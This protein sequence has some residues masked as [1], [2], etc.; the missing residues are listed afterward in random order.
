MR[1]RLVWFLFLVAT[2]FLAAHVL[3]NPNATALE[4]PANRALLLIVVVL[5]IYSAAAVGTWL[6]I[7]A[8]RLRGVG[9][10]P[11][12]STLVTLALTIL[13]WLCVCGSGAALAAL[14]YLGPK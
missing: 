2:V 9:A 4:M 11:K 7:N 12:R 8:S 3:I 6:L 13:V 14:R 5:A 10:A 1:A